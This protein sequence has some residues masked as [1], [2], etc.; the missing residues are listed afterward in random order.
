MGPWLSSSSA[1]ASAPSGAHFPGDLVRSSPA[2]GRAARGRPSS[3]REVAPQIPP[4]GPGRIPISLFPS[5]LLL[6]R[7]S[8]PPCQVA[9]PPEAGPPPPFLHQALPPLVA[10]QWP[11]LPVLLAVPLLGA[12]RA[13]PNKSPH[14][15][16]SS[17]PW[18][19]PGGTPDTAAQYL[20][21]ALAILSVPG[22]LCSASPRCSG[23]TDGSEVA[24]TP[25][26]PGFWSG[27]AAGS[28]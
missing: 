7:C 25:T 13:P 14:S 11:S 28:R 22:L 12:A 27:P 24:A 2:G 26:A 8:P 15:L 23:T 1:P 20:G 16:G 4:T 9:P 5:M 10:V 18:A 19:A 6:R 17:P 3:P 21:A